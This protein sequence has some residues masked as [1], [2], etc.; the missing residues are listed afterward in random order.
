MS[1]PWCDLGDAGLL[2]QRPRQES[3]AMRR[4]RNDEEFLRRLD[5][6]LAVI[7]PDGVVTGRHPRAGYRRV[8]S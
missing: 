4:R 2:K 7:D 8:E 6:L 1:G 5:D 3:P